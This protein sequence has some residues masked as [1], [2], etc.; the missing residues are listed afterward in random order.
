LAYVPALTSIQAIM[1][2]RP[3]ARLF[4]IGWVAVALATLVAVSLAWPSNGLGMPAVGPRGVW[5]GLPDIAS[6]DAPP[7]LS[8][9]A[10]LDHGLY[11][12]YDLKFAEGRQHFAQWEQQH[13][14]DP[15]GPSLEAASDLFQEFYSEGMLTSE[16]FGDEKR[17]FDGAPRKPDR[18]LE[19]GFNDAARRSEERA[20]RLLDSNPRDPDALFALTLDAGM[21]ANHF[22]LIEKRQVESLRQLREADRNA[23][24]LLEVAP[25]A[26]DAYLALG[27][28]NYIIGCLPGYKRAVLWFGGIHGD[29]AVGLQQLTRVAKQGHYLR[30]YAK[31]LLALAAMREHQLPVARE[32]LTQLAAEFPENPLY[33][34]ELGKIPE[35]AVLCCSR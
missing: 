6:T 2:W 15:L 24:N 20:H 32:Q 22:S 21:L 34:R 7:R 33:A 27:M 14:S 4:G 8:E 25:D 30:P 26:D 35:P 9:D 17:M 13:P 31:L 1:L 11:L 28:A 23:R 18:E 29:K 10:D 19:A 12:L 3:T 5:L 16:F